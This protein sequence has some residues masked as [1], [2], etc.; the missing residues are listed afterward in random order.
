MEMTGTDQKRQWGQEF[1]RTIRLFSGAFLFGIPFVYTMEMW[2]IGMYVDLWK[3]LLFIA[4]A[5]F[6]GV[7]LIY[8][9]TPQNKRDLP[10]S[11]M[12]TVNS[13]AVGILSS[14]LVLVVL[15]EIN[16]TVPL[17]SAVGMTAVMTVPLSI[18]ASASTSI[19]GT[20]QSQNRQG[21]PKNQHKGSQWRKLANDIGATAAG[22][23]FI[24]LPIAPTRE[25]PRLAATMGYWNL[26]M[27][28]A[29]SLAVTYLIVFV[30]GFT[31]SN[32]PYRSSGPFQHPLTETVLAYILSL[33]IALV[34]LYLFGV[35]HFSQPLY[36]LMQHVLVLGLPT[37]VGGAAGRLVL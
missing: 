14:L 35:I 1:I 24:G 30:A 20:K 9:S 7:T 31:A 22:G 34:T 12:Q 6:V 17:R 23:I 36:P 32:A 37:T 13:V 26:L 4:I 21:N 33:L 18:G 29:L 3:L 27:V 28:I 10:G 2:W 8:F 5:F 15:N 16:L 25:V 11:F 19:L